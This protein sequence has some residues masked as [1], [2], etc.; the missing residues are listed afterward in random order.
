MKRKLQW[1]MVA[2]LGYDNQMFQ[3]QSCLDIQIPDPQK[4]IQ[5]SFHD[6]NSKFPIRSTPLQLKLRTISVCQEYIS[7][8]V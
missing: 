1:Q 4:L 3:P 6:C 8:P 2:H 5:E 7:I